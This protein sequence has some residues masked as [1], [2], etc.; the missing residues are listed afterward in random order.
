MTST[1]EREKKRCSE[2]E[3]EVQRLAELESQA[4]EQL[5]KRYLLGFED[6]VKMSAPEFYDRG[7]ADGVDDTTRRHFELQ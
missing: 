2:L 3:L 1:N 4:R 7:Y 5:E 6:G